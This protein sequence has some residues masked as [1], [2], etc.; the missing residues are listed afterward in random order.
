MRRTW[1]I[2]ILCAVVAGGTLRLWRLS[3]VPVALYCDEALQGYEAYCLLKTGADSRGVTMPLFFSVFGAGW[4]EPLYIYLTTLP[5]AILGNTEAATRVVAAAG[6]TL[7]LLAV[8]WLGYGLGGARAAGWAC[9]LMAVSPWALHLSRIGF[10]ASLLPLFLA[11]GGAALL[12]GASAGGGAP[13][14]PHARGA[15]IEAPPPEAG[16]RTGEKK[17][18]SASGDRPDGRAAPGRAGVPPSRG[19][20]T[21]FRWLALGAAILT[22]AL[23]TYVAARILVPLLLLLFGAAFLPRLRAIG[24]GRRAILAVIVVVIALPV[25]LFSLTPEAHARYVDVGVTS[26][27]SGGEALVKFLSVYVSH[28]SPGFLLTQGDPIGRHSVRDFGMLHAHD[29]LFLLAGV[30]VAL[31]RRSRA[32]L[33]LLGWLLAGPIP[34]ALGIDPRHAVRAI[35]TIPALYALAGSGAAALFG[36]GGAAEISRVRGRI[37][38][39]VILV[40]AAVSSAAYLHHYFFVY[41]AYSGPDWQYGLKEAFRILREEAQGHDS[42]YVTTGED[43]PYIHRLYLFSFPP[44]EWQERGFRRTKYFFDPPPLEE[45]ER[46]TGMRTPLYLLKPHEVP[47]R[48]MRRKTVLHPDGTPAYIV[49]W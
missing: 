14:P 7:A 40:A 11:A 49:A 21:G 44:E 1:L 9:A 30:L 6:G 26:Y 43:S 5:V 36:P 22:L 47:A 33:F 29:L 17:P 34:A 46:A 27:L 32:D 35:G 8:A 25:V 3:S 12:K 38:L 2:V 41:P 19:G 24:F 23:Y 4:E 28:F 31:R 42:I 37:V 45:F 39:A 16:E 18:T 10:Q 20:A 15:A 13:G 48:L